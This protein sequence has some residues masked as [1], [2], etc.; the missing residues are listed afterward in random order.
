MKL[1]KKAPGINVIDEDPLGAIEFFKKSRHPIQFLSC[2]PYFDP[3]SLY[4]HQDAVRKNLR[5]KDVFL[6]QAQHWWNNCIISQ[7]PDRKI[8]GVHIR[9]EDYKNWMGGKYYFETAVFK[10][11]M[12]ETSALFLNEKVTFIIFTNGNLQEKDL[13]SDQYQL[14][15]SDNSA[16]VDLILMSKCDFIIGPPSTFSGYASFMGK[17]PK[18]IMLHQDQKI[19][20][21]DD[22][23]IYMIDC[24][25]D[26][27]DEN[28]NKI[29]TRY[30]KGIKL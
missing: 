27:L 12:E 3:Y 21:E 5:P 11:K 29:L 19:E 15:F 6:T 8:V 2:W 17:A 25:D 22:F 9:Q 14:I 23:G 18:Y 7:Y 16:I 26:E 10:S 30:H 1:F 13:A 28:G 24:M 4:Q 20:S